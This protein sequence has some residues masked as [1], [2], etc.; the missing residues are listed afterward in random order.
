MIPMP[1][2]SEAAATNSGFEHGYI[3]PQIIGCSE[4]VCC[5]NLLS[6]IVET[7][8]TR[9]AEVIGELIYSTIKL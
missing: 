4:P 2:A 9:V 1:P 6:D 5:M 3:A 8:I 7:L